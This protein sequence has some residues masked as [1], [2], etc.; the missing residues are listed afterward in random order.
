MRLSDTL[1]RTRLRGCGPPLSRKQKNSYSL[2]CLF[3]QPRSSV[4]AHSS[5]PFPT[6]HCWVA[7][8]CPSPVTVRAAC[9]RSLRRSHTSQSPA[10]LTYFL[11]TCAA[12]SLVVYPSPIIVG[13][14]I[15]PAIA[16]GAHVPWRLRSFP[17]KPRA[18]TSVAGGGARASRLTAGCMLQLL[19]MDLT[20]V[21]QMLHMLHIF[22]SVFSCMLR[23][24]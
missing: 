15:D 1:V 19:H 16:A 17:T 7:A 8:L 3:A 10:P 6:A 4:T 13:W 2:V 11:V 18:P 24:F 5:V 12:R 21:D 14:V 23:E 22:A 20:K 9:P